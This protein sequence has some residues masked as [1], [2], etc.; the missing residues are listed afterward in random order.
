VSSK[1]SSRYSKIK[2]RESN[3]T[4]EI[5]DDVI[6]DLYE[7][8]ENV[9][10]AMGHDPKNAEQKSV[11][12]VKS[13]ENAG[14]SAPARKG[15]KNK[16]DP[17][18]KVQ[19][20]DPASKMQDAGAQPT[21]GY[22]PKKTKAAMMNDMYTKMTKTKKEDLATMYSKFMAEDIEDDETVEVKSS[23]V[24]VDVDWSSDLNALVNEEATLSEEFKGKAQTIFEAAINSKLS[25]E[26]D[27][28]EEKFNE[29]L[30]SEVST[31]KEELVNKVDSYLNYV[32]E[33][34]MEENKVAVQTG[35]RTEIAEK[36]MNN[37]KDL[38]T[39]SYIEVPES[40]VDLV[41]DLAAEVEELETTLNSQTAKT[42]AM[43]EELEDY[44][45]EAVIR[46]A[47]NDLAETQIEKL[48]TLT[49]S[50]DF[51]DKETF[52]TKVNTVKESYF[53]KKPVTSELDNLEE[54]TE[55][56][57]VE[58]SGAMSQYLTALKSQIKT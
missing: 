30:E 56:N 6:G 11:A 35:L 8:D 3:M 7:E 14:K 26:I 52:A 16:K 15:D 20:S 31:T 5:K 49:N 34:W 32:V 43:Q 18:Q 33:N 45:R 53:K 44:Q 4:E 19:S 12:S 36:F 10:E 47:S 21:E 2:I 54:D 17:M 48:K 41:D 37:L 38:F 24:K 46:E 27:R 57:T 9:E 42:I 1:I 51:D 50:I 39:E 58:T 40:K 22:M 23:N 13:A 55:D 29:E 25:E 28:L